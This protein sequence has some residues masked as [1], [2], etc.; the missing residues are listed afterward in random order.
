GR[1]LVPHEARYIKPDVYV[2]DVD[3]DYMYYLNEGRSGRLRI[4]RYYRDLLQSRG[5][6]AGFTPAEKEFTIT[7]YKNAVWLIKNIEKR[8]ETVLRVTEAIMNY[9]RE[10]LD[11]GIE[12]LRPLTLKIGR[13]HV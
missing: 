5:G 12:H 10:F 3:G 1:E 11:K 13:A 2:K 8:K 4:N 9:Q 6:A 7:K